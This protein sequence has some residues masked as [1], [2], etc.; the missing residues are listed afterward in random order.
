MQ[1]PRGKSFRKW[2]YGQTT[3]KGHKIQ[4]PLDIAVRALEK[5]LNPH[6]EINNNPELKDIFVERARGMDIIRFMNMDILAVCFIYIYRMEIAP[7]NEYNLENFTIALRVNKITLAKMKP[8]VK[9]INQS[10]RSL[11]KIKQQ[12]DQI[13]FEIQTTMVR[14]IY[15]IMNSGN[16]SVP[17]VSDHSDDVPILSDGSS[18][19][20]EAPS[21]SSLISDF[22]IDTDIGNFDIDNTDTERDESDD[23]DDI[24]LEDLDI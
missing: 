24:N 22:D 7:N 14:Y 15:A 13:E 11:R 12:R 16:E 18:D 3:F 20:S 9:R 19:T 8:Y 1:E 6:P 5:A 21:E 2:R 23:D 10:F 4:T 17:D